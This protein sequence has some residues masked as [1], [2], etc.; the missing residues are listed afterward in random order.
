[1]VVSRN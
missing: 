1:M